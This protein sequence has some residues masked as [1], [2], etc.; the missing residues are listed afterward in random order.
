MLDKGGI[1]TILRFVHTIVREE[2]L[3]FS[4]GSGGMGA[5]IR[6]DDIEG[7]E[8]GSGPHPL[9]PDAGPHTGTLPGDEVANIP[10]GGI[11][12]TTVQAALNELD[13]EKAPFDEIRDADNDTKVQVE[14]SADEDIIRMDVAGV[15][16]FNLDAVGILALA[17]QAR[18]FVYRTT[19]VQT[20]PTGVT[21]K[22][23]LDA[24][25]FDEQ[26]EFD[27]DVNYRFTATNDGYYLIAGAILWQT[28]TEGAAYRIYIKKN[29]ADILYQAGAPSTAD[30]FS[31][32]VPGVIYL[33]ANDSIEVH[34]N[35]STGG[36][37]DVYFGPAYSYLSVHKLS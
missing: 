36:N 35:Q 31:N 26:N 23:E 17:K 18:C 15:E 34:V 37:D 33:A 7:G 8:S 3:R 13:A 11:A 10:A 1:N 16:A 4:R 28:V 19:L 25:V 22:V 6:Y 12:A 2:L 20:I 32:V 24:E 5:S 30:F 9:D 21:T 29:G 27:K 14:E